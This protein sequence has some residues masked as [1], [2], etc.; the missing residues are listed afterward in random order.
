MEIVKNCAVSVEGVEWFPAQNINFLCQQQG[1]IIT[2]VDVLPAGRNKCLLYNAIYE[3]HGKLFLI[4]WY[5]QNIL[6]YDIKNS[7]FFSIENNVL[8]NWREVEWKYACS[9]VWDHY[10]YAF[11]RCIPYIVKID[12]FTNE[13]MIINEAAEG[14][15]KRLDEIEPFKGMYFAH[16]KAIYG[17]SVWVLSMNRLS[18]VIELNLKNDMIQC[19]KLPIGCGAICQAGEGA[20]WLFSRK[21]NCIVRWDRDQGV[22][23]VINQ[24]DVHSEDGE[25]IF[26]N[27]NG[28]LE[29]RS[30]IECIYIDIKSGQRAREKIHNGTKTLKCNECSDEIIY[31]Y[32]STIADDTIYSENNLQFLGVPL[33]IYMKY[34][35]ERSG[36]SKKERSKINSGENIYLHTKL[37]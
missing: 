32:F 31:K 8:C 3:F 22:T 29:C 25:L 30:N 1:E 37:W 7:S 16:Q 14:E 20:L 6:V 12:M 5:A 35:K 17:E 27:N 19:H 21:N 26:E 34:I 24:I 11:G 2:C 33:S 36:K 28:I 13:I 18:M 9:L 15:I 23:E 4:P 10:I